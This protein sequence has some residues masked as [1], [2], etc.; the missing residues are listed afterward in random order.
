MTTQNRQRASVVVALVALAGALLGG[1]IAGLIDGGAHVATASFVVGTRDLDPTDRARASSNLSDEAKIPATYAAV[2]ESE[3]IERLAIAQ[4]EASDSAS[5]VTIESEVATG[6]NIVAITA[7][8]SDPAM[9][10]QLALTVGELTTAYIDDLGDVYT[11]TLL[12][13][14]TGSNRTSTSRILGALVGG[15]VGILIGIALIAIKHRQRDEAEFD[16]DAESALD[17]AEYGRLRLREETARSDRSGVP[18]WL[19]TVRVTF[20]WRA[21][22]NKSDEL[23][24][25]NSQDRQHIIEEIIPTLRPFDQLLDVDRLEA[26]T[27]AAILPALDDD[28]IARLTRHWRDDIRSRLART[29]GHGAIVSVSSCRYTDHEFVGDAHATRLAEAL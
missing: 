2:A 9:A 7:R 28:E 25:P 10:Q 16:H 1:W 13:A 3:R 27:L 4:L 6:S 5:D 18:F 21:S 20:P 19:A 12:D 29:H 14:P 22:G 24:S 23:A 17:D 8:A 26:D 15:I 11:L